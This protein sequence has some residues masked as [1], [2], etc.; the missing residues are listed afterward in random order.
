MPGLFRDPVPVVD[1]GPRRV[2]RRTDGKYLG[3]E[4]LLESW[5]SD[6]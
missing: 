2:G 4:I 5:C 6:G 1:A 3:K